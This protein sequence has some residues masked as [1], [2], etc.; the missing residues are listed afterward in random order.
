MKNMENKEIKILKM[1]NGEIILSEVQESEDG[2]FLTK[3]VEIK[4]DPVQQG[5]G[6]MDYD[7]LYR[8]KLYEETLF[9]TERHVMAVINDP[10]EDLVNQYIQLK[11][12]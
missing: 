10:A 7:A 12:E 5:I 2:Y 11:G 9:V 3:P 6:F 8:G 1:V 4:F